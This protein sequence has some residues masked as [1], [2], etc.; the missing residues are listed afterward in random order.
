MLS[1]FSEK[2]FKDL[3]IFLWRLNMFK[4]L[5]RNLVERSF[6]LKGESDLDKI[7][8]L[9]SN[10]QE[11]EQRKEKIR[12]GILE[13]SGV[14]NKLKD[15]LPLNPIIRDMRL[16]GDYTVSSV[17]FET[18]PG[19]FHSGSLYRPQMDGTPKEKSVAAVL[20]PHGHFTFGRFEPDN[21]NLA[22]D[23]ARMGAYAFVYDMIGY[24][25][26]EQLEHKIKNAFQIQLW[27]SIR[28]LDFILG[29]PEVDP[30]RIAITGASGGGTQSFMLSAVDDR[31]RLCAPVVMVSSRFYGGCVCESGMPVHKSKEH[32]YA[33]NNA[34]IAA[35]TAPRP[36]L[37]VSIGKDWTRFVPE[38]EYPF[39]KRIFGFYGAEEKVENV[40]LPQ[41]AH[42]YH[43]SK[44]KPVLEFI[45]K[46][47]NL[48]IQ[49]IKNEK[50]EIDETLNVIESP[51]EMSVYRE[52][53]L[54]PKKLSS[55]SL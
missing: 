5:Y 10:K 24:G 1:G 39:I 7:K 29:F 20:I 27:N 2:S 19:F 22:A 4:K 35:M 21:Q 42:N 43:Y 8:A 37:L 11:W 33:T 50:G 3:K 12:N 16:H 15:R 36:L 49:K 48:P 14:K 41:E 26:N 46:H 52:M 9:Y 28:S 54:K 38:R 17:Y 51:E 40:H 30:Q 34:E 47:F 53:D 44:R 13:I 25:N 45:A 18:L 55:I 32:G 23:L 6:P 31:V